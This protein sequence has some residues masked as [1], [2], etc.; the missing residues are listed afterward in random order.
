MLA[1]PSKSFCNSKEYLFKIIAEVCSFEFNEPKMKNLFS[2][3]DSDLVNFLQQHRPLPPKAN[4][5]LETQLMELIERQPQ[6][7][8][9]KLP[10]LLWAVPGAIAMVV[11]TYS[12]QRFLEPTPQ[13]TQDVANMELFL[14]NSWEVTINESAFS[15][16]PEAE[17]YQLLSTV[18]SP[19]MISAK[20]V[21]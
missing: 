21:K 1:I 8:V 11:V 14:T 6:K 12:S 17:I 9:K 3:N 4:P 2:D 5:H 18:E 16:T 10:G 7:S 15:T 13:L 20:A 19:K